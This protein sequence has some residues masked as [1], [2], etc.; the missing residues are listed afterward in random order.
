MDR[1][2]QDRWQSSGGDEADSTVLRLDGTIADAEAL[3]I[4]MAWDRYRCDVVTLDSQGVIQRIQGLVF[5]APRSWIE[6]RLARQMV[7]E[8]PRVLMWVKGLSGV[9]GDETV[10]ARAEREVWMEERMHLPD[11]VTPAASDKL[12][13]CTPRRP[14]T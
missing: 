6:E 14:P 11:I 13:H 4:S 9:E 10:D 5:Q 2:E 12:I 3:G 8:P 7:A 1:R